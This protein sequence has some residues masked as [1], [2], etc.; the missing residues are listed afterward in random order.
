M[1]SP[2][3]SLPVIGFDFAGGKINVPGSGN[4]PISFTAVS[5]IVRYIGYVLTSLP[6]EKIEN[7][8]FRIEGSKNVSNI[9]I[10]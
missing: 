6:K 7:R 8:T 5:D 2:R 4:A 10:L 1:N 3:R 9:L